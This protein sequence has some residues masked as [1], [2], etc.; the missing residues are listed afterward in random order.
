M[1]ELG[2]ADEALAWARRG[3]AETSG[4]QAAKLFDLA[5][6]LLSD[7]GDVNEVFE[8]RRHQHECT[9]GS[10]TYAELQTAARANG[11]WESEVGPA[12]AVLAERDLPGLID[13]LLADGEPE[14]AWTVATAWDRQLLPSQWLRIAEAREP[15]EPADAL[16][17][18]LRL[19]DL[20]LLD[21]NKGAYKEGVRHLK[22]AR[23]AATSA[24]RAPEFTENLN[25]LRE[26]N[27]RRP[28]LMAMLDKAGLR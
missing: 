16:T 21:A 13:A 9:P 7:A 3:I 25:D 12:R 27:R 8:L 14:A 11:T 20:A 10:S 18:Y 19:V 22:A 1:V 6:N 15:T 28:T 17:V 24:D 5:A 23:R 26:R 4:W 2:K